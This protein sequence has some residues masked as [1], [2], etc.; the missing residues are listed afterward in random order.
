MWRVLFS[1]PWARKEI[2]VLGVALAQ[3]VSIT[4]RRARALVGARHVVVAL[5]YGLSLATRWVP[6]EISVAGKPSRRGL[7]PF[8]KDW[9]HHRGA[10]LRQSIPKKPPFEWRTNPRSMPNPCVE[11]AC[12]ASLLRPSQIWS[13]TAGYHR[14]HFGLQR[15]AGTELPLSRLSVFPIPGS[16]RGPDDSERLRAVVAPARAPERRRAGRRGRGLRQ[17]SFLGGQ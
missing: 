17:R 16:V 7:H 3:F 10:R 4:G 11:S 14:D 13:S 2:T 12:F 8:T 15:E 6:S 5:T 9:P 1:T